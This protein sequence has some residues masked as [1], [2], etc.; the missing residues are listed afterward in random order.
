MEE[1]SHADR[2]TDGPDPSGMK[3]RIT[4]LSKVLAVE[5]NMDMK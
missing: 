4:P 1:Q 2:T 5:G 3:V